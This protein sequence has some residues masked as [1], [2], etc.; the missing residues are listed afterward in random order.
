MTLRTHDGSVR[1]I[2]AICTADIFT[3]DANNTA[4]R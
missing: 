1:H 3:F 2:S 4:A